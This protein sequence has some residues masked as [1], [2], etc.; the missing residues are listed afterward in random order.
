MCRSIDTSKS[1][2]DWQTWSAEFIKYIPNTAEK[3]A[4]P[5]SGQHIMVPTLFTDL[6][7]TAISDFYIVTQTITLNAEDRAEFEEK[8]EL[9]DNV[10]SA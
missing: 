8:V 6:E 1:V 10:G 4:V 3:A 2:T 7:L 5:G 9:F